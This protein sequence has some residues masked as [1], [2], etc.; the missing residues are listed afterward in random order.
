MIN[1][2]MIFGAFLL[3]FGTLGAFITTIVMAVL[4]K[5][6]VWIAAIC[7]PICL[8]VSFIMLGVGGYMYGETDEYKESVKQQEIE[9]QQKAE[10][11]R[12]KKEEE[13]RKKAEEEKIAKEKAEEERIRKESEEKKRLEEERL[14]KQKAEEE[15]IKKEEEDRKKAEEEK[16]N[17]EKEIKEQA[18]ELNYK[19]VMRNPDNYVGQYFCV[20]VKIS[21]VEKGSLFSGYERA[22]KSHTNDELDWWLGD[23]IYLVDNRDEKEDG[24]LKI[25]EDDIAKIYGKFDG[26]IETKNMLNNTKGEEMS[27]EVLYVE[28]IEE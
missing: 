3:I 16:A 7:V 12:L 24:Y 26:L 18:Q 2:L 11:E 10:E 5:K 22:Y 14:E 21:T 8:I 25:L 27:L 20:T 17:T 9:K 19:D 28:L 23:L 4:K 15:R 6:K 1:F 13:D